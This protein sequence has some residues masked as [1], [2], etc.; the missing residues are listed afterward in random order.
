MSSHWVNHARIDIEG[1]AGPAIDFHD[2]ICGV[3]GLN[4]V[5]CHVKENE[6]CLVLDTLVMDTA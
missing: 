5:C 3:I 4:A 2:H 6:I 1:L